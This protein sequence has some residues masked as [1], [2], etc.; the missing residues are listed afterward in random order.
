MAAP[1]GTTI[2]SREVM[3]VHLQY[4]A[5]GLAFEGLIVAA[6]AVGRGMAQIV[7]SKGEPVPSMTVVICR[8]EISAAREREGLP[9]GRPTKVVNPGCAHKHFVLEGQRA[10]SFVLKSQCKPV[11]ACKDVNERCGCCCNRLKKN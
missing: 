8:Q 4:T 5:G 9:I 7:D 10:A 6:A 1:K 11:K 3:L 2:A